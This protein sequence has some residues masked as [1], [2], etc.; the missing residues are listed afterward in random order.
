[1]DAWITVIDGERRVKTSDLPRSPADLA[2]IRAVQRHIE[3]L[4]RLDAI[5]TQLDD[6]ADSETA[7]TE[8]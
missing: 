7:E 6:A 5:A 3:L 8:T 1:M 4:D 2:E